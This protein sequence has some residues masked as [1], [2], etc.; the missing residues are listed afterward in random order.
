[1]ICK[2]K[3]CSCCSTFCLYECAY[4]IKLNLDFCI[5]NYICMCVNNHITCI[6]FSTDVWLLSLETLILYTVAMYSYSYKAWFA[7]SYQF[8]LSVYRGVQ[9]LWLCNYVSYNLHILHFCMAL[10]YNKNNHKFHWK[11]LYIHTYV[12]TYVDTYIC[13]SSNNWHEKTGFSNIRICT[14]IALKYI[15]D[16][17]KYLMWNNLP[18]LHGT[19][20][21][22]NLLQIHTVLIASSR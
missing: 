7:V 19:P 12:H 6:H 17:L 4:N 18:M 1:M 3:L 14:L 9:L 21:A 5:C 22:W 16:S 15:M 11:C 10:L 20:L 13:M 2:S 8:H